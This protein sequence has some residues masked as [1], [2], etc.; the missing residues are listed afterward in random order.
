MPTD[1][2]SNNSSGYPT[3]WHAKNG[4]LSSSARAT[5]APPATTARP[6]VGTFWVKASGSQMATID[7]AG[8]SRVDIDATMR[9]LDNK[10]MDD[11]AVGKALM[12]VLV[13]PQHRRPSVE[14]FLHALCIAEGGA[15]WVAHTHAVSVNAILC[16]VRGAEPFRQHLFPDGIVVCGPE[17]AVVPYVDPGLPLAQAVRDEL[18]RFQDEFGF[19]PKLLLMEN[20][21]LVGLGQIRGRGA[22]HQPHGRQVGQDAA[23][24]VRRGRTQCALAAERRPHRQPPGRA[25]PSPTTRR[26]GRIVLHNEPGVFRMVT[27]QQPQGQD[28]RRRLRR[29]RHRLLPALPHARP[30]RRPRRRLR[31]ARRAH[32]GLYAS[33]RRKGAVPRLLRDDRPG[34]HRRRVDPHRAGH[35]RPLH[36]QGRGGRQARPAAEAHGHRHGRRAPHRGRR[37]QGGRQGPHRAQLQLAARPGLCAH[38]L[39]REAGRAGRP[40]LVQPDAHRPDAVSPVSGQ[41][42]LRPG[43]LL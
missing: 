42:P 39:A 43:R 22:Q 20:H 37:A 4:S 35:A 36:A 40:A 1:Q 12:D 19:S 17:V 2:F 8:F 30:E 34:R 38:P 29:R 5:P 14:T 11:E 25:L 6:D 10:S 16:S 41:Q 9:L 31:P 26:Q 3:N 32:A 21:G 23:G 18:H 24:R 28:R 7:A 15:K 13:D 27:A 33:V